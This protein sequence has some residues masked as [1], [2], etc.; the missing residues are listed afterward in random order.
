MRKESEE[1]LSSEMLTLLSQSRSQTKRER[2]W[3]VWSE[4]RGQETGKYGTRVRMNFAAHQ[5]KKENKNA[6]MRGRRKKETDNQF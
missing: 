5:E 4:S 1:E 6:G 2:R 3:G